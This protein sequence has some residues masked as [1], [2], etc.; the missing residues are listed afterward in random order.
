MKPY[1]LFVFFFLLIFY[2]ARLD[3]QYPKY[4]ITLMAAVKDSFTNMAYPESN[5]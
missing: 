1:S 3:A 2:F 5:M 4:E